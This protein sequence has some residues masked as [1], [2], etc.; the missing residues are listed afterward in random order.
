ME[1]EQIEEW[2]GQDVVD[3]DG[4]K[5]GKLEDVYFEAGSREP[6]FGCIK[7]GMLGRRHILV[8][9]TGA[10][11]SRD[12]VRVAYQQDQVK[13]GPRV[14]PGATLESGTEQELAHHYQIELTP[15]PAV[16]EPRY[17]SASSR[18]ER[19]ARAREA[20][21]RAEQLEELAERKAAEARES[22]T[23]ADETRRQAQ[24]AQDEHDRA[25]REAAE[26]RA[27]AEDEASPSP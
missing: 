8:P 19:E 20:T 1:I 9:L 4:E 26:A 14:E 21:Q 3:C 27:E 23:Q 5:I 7:T 10:S 24:Q 15:A 22:E 2:K 25:A 11:V 6:A 13:D 16:G 18:A 12:Y 17:E